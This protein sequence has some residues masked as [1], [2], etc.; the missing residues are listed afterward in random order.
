MTNIKELK[1]A[2]RFLVIFLA[3]YIG[4]NVVYGLWITSYGN[5]P[6][7]ATHMVTQH[8]SALLTVLGE[9]TSTLPKLGTASISIV[10]GLRTV[11]SVFEGCN[12]INVMIVF[13]AFVFAFGGKPK[14]MAW[15]IPAGLVL[16]YMLNLVRVLALF[17][18]A[19]YWE[20]YFYYVHKYAFTAFIYVF[21]FALWWIWIE[22]VS[23][24]S[25]RKNWKTSDHE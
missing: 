2:I 15:F 13:V 18:V 11:I 8:T 4:L 23:G 21:V 10:K 6:D 25:I 9:E 17:Y 7:A 14:T 1:P 5:N 24:I 19:E 12:S 16:I 22:R 20:Q 3:L